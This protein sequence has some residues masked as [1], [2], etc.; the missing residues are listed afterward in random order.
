MTMQERDAL[1]KLKQMLEEITVT[2]AEY[3]ANLKR[4]ETRKHYEVARLMDSS[5]F[6]AGWRECAKNV[7][8]VIDFLLA[9]PS[10]RDLER[11]VRSR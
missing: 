1:L 3:D 10:K 11:F 2:A 6:K 7:E 8:G 9:S 4:T 5:D